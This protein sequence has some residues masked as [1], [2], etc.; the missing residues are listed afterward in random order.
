MTQHKEI[1]FAVHP[2]LPI[3]DYREQALSSLWTFVEGSAGRRI[4]RLA[5]RYDQSFS[6]APK[7][8]CRHIGAIAICWRER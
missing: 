3:V 2:P 6:L 4:P 7:D 8:W 5:S 1:A